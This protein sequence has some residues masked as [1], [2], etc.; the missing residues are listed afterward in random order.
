[1]ELVSDERFAAI[2]ASLSHGKGPRE[3]SKNQVGYALR[4]A[5]MLPTEGYLSSLP[6]GKYSLEKIKSLQIPQ[7]PISLEAALRT[8]D[9]MGDGSI[10]LEDF[11]Y[12]LEAVGEPLPQQQVEDLI[13]MARDSCTIQEGGRVNIGHLVHSIKTHYNVET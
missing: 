11:L 5:G 12:S 3:L 2:I 6:D 1:M 9:D 13:V 8:F 4:V 10:S 7:P